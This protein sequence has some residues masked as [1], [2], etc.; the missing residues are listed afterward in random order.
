MR[1]W[2]DDSPLSGEIRGFLNELASVTDKV[3]WT[4]KKADASDMRLPA[5][6]I[7]DSAGKSSGIYFHG[8][9][10]GHEFNSFIIALYN[11]AGPGQQ[12]D[13][14]TSDKIKALSAEK[15]IKVLVSLTCTMCPESVMAAQ[16]I[17]ADSEHVTAE[18][19][20]LSHFPDLKERYNVMSVPCIVINDEKI[21]FGKK[22]VDEML[23]LIA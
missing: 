14:Q 4:E 11:V 17:A 1:A 13:S 7:L 16:R 3:G 22:N 10:G 6:E 12:L 23:A 20:D 21:V 2:L 15:N 8:V 5:I 9:P 19:F 18:M